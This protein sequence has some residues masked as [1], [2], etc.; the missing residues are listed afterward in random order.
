MGPQSGQLYETA[1]ERTTLWGHRADNSMITYR[2]DN[3]IEAET[4]GTTL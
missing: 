1:T 2:T 3:S 4:E